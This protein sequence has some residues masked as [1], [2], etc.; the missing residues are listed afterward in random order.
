MRLLAGMSPEHISSF[1]MTRTLSESGA[2][3]MDP[4]GWNALYVPAGTPSAVADRLNMEMRKFM[5]DPQVQ[6][7]LRKLGY[8]PG[9]CKRRVATSSC[10]SRRWKSPVASDD[11]QR[12]F[13]G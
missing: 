4:V 1:P 11:S 3:S 8:E 7:Q 2:P 6:A 5:A 10:G 12:K 13:E 9:A